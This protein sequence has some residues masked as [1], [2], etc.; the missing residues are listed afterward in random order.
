MLSSNSSTQLQYGNTGSSPCFLEQSS[1]ISF[2]SSLFTDGLWCKMQSA[3]A[4]KFHAKVDWNGCLFGFCM[5]TSLCLGVLF[6]WTKLVFTIEYHH[7]GDCWYS[8]CLT[9]HCQHT[10]LI[11]LTERERARLIIDLNWHKIKY[12]FKKRRL[13]IGLFWFQT[14]VWHNCKQFIHERH[15]TNQHYYDL[16]C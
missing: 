5:A 16:N 10:T 8:L 1:N 12:M 14:S 15:N 7:L 4:V 2:L 3:A 9:R 11:L 6:L 13:I